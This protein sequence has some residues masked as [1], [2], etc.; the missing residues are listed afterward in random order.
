MENYLLITHFALRIVIVS[1]N[2]LCCI[3]INDALVHG[4]NMSVWFTRVVIMSAGKGVLKSYPVRVCF[5]GK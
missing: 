2:E 5:F 1:T 4:T 3:G